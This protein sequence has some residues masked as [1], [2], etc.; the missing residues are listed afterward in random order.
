MAK[1]HAREETPPPP[2]AGPLERLFEI[3]Q[4]RR[5][6][7]PVAIDATPVERAAIADAL[8]IAAVDQLSL[9]GRIEPSG[10]SNWRFEGRLQ[11]AAVQSC[12]V[13]LDPAPQAI[14][15]PLIRHWSP[16]AATDGATYGANG[17]EDAAFIALDLEAE[18]DAPEPLEDAVDL[19]AAAVEALALALEPYPRAPGAALEHAE[20][21]PAG[22]EPLTD[23]AIRPF[24]GLAALKASMTPPSADKD[25]PQAGPQAAPQADLDEGDDD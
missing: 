24:A 18:D 23:E 7:I 16:N 8:S 10:R 19:G 14:D 9:T 3:D 6:P 17:L 5:K 25:A 2:A 12:V 21:R 13:S 15:E 1:D 22:A 20:A 11:A 4:R